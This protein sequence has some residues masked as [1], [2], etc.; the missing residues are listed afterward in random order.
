MANMTS[1]EISTTGD[2]SQTH[3]FGKQ[4]EEPSKLILYEPNRSR[5]R[6]E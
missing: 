6:Q 2:N 1:L 4:R 3:S 5:S